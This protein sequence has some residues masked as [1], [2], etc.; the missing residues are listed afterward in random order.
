MPPELKP[1]VFNR[2]SVATK[3]TPAKATTVIATQ[4]TTP[5]AEPI[6]TGPDQVA[7]R[8][9]FD[10]LSNKLRMHQMNEEKM[11]DAEYKKALSRA[12]DIVTLFNQTSAGPRSKAKGKA[13]T[14]TPVSLTDL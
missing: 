9:E 5:P 13:N 11:E 10:E 14:P 8:R 4:T 1:I 6:P 7:L 12:L 3:P 2:A